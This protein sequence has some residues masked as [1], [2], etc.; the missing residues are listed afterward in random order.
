[1]NNG[2]VSLTFV[3]CTW[4][5]EWTGTPQTFMNLRVRGDLDYMDLEHVHGAN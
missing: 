2:Q 5:V 4:M 3:L 1:M